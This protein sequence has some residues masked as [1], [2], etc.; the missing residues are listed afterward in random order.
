MSDRRYSGSCMCGAV[1]YVG[2]GTA[3]GLCY[4]HCASC[5]RATGAPFVAWA[6]LDLGLF[7]FGDTKPELYK[8][9][10]KVSRTFCGACGTSLTYQHEGR[11]DEIDVTIATLDNPGQLEPE[12]HIGVSDKLPWLRLED[13]LPQHPEWRR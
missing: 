11:P 4:C 1:R 3:T 8:S 13:G 5:R 12:C 6:T 7:S 9:S 2:S 10:P